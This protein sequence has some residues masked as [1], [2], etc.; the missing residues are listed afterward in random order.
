MTTE[1]YTT[2][3]VKAEKKHTGDIIRQTRRVQR[4]SRGVEF[5]V[6]AVAPRGLGC[7]GR[8]RAQERNH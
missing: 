7:G 4:E 1:T 8:K 2:L 5:K 3:S 6:E